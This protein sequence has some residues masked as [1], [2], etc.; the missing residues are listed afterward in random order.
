MNK[1]DYEK[2]VASDG[3][4]RIERL[5]LRTIFGTSNMVIDDIDRKI[6]QTW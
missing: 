6:L 5:A 3:F 2:R 4:G 1:L